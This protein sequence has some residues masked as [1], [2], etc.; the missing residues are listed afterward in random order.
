M[1]DSLNVHLNPG[2]LTMLSRGIG[3]EA[4]Q[5]QLTSGQTVHWIPDPQIRPGGCLVEGGDQVVDARL[6]TILERVLRA[7][8]DG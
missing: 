1:T 7:L 5:P 4:A 6:S 2:D 8:V 3:G